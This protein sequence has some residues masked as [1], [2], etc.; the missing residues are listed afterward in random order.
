MNPIDKDTLPETGQANQG[1]NTDL[2]AT[3]TP[4]PKKRGGARPGAGRKPSVDKAAIQQAKD[5]VRAEINRKTQEAIRV[6][7]DKE[8][9]EGEIT[10]SEIPLL[11]IVQNSRR[12]I[13]KKFPRILE[14]LFALMEGGIQ[15]VRKYEVAALVLVDTYTEPDANGRQ[16]KAKIQ[17]FPNAKP[18]EMVLTCETIT[19]YPPDAA[20]TQFL[21]NRLAGRPSEE[22][23]NPLDESGEEK[24][25]VTREE[26]FMDFMD[27]IMARVGKHR[28]PNTLPLMDAVTKE[29]TTEGTSPTEESASNE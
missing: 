12:H 22:K 28:Q 19:N 9:V 29:N 25:V 10:L 2:P 6:A 26:M 15:V 3:S 18:D 1:D 14:S 13:G 23:V 4:V 7:I 8:N 20:V 24:P 16:N 21:F 11:V 27:F 5:A 17:A